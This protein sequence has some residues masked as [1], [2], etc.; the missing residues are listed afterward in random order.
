MPCV[1][2]RFR[3]GLATLSYVLSTGTRLYR[4]ATRTESWD[5]PKRVDPRFPSLPLT[6]TRPVIR[7]QTPT[8]TPTP[9]PRM[10]LQRGPAGDISK[11]LEHRRSLR[12]WPCRSL[13]YPLG[14]R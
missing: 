7:R 3:P 4:S 5:G 2:C 1:I 6:L 14:A 13:E 10:H 9:T 8:L 11:G 12:N